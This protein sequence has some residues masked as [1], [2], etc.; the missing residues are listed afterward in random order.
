MIVKRLQSHILGLQSINITPL[1]LICMFNFNHNANPVLDAI[2]KIYDLTKNS[3]IA[4][5]TIKD[6]SQQI[7]IV[8]EFF[9]CLN[10]QAVL[11]SIMIQ[12]QLEN[13]PVSTKRILEHTDLRTSNALYI[14]EV[15]SPLV[16]KEWINPKKDLKFHPLSEYTINNKIIRSVLTGKMEMNNEVKIENSFQL[17]SHFQSKLSE[18]GN[19]RISYNDFI[20]WTYEM[21]QANSCIELAAFTIQLKMSPED[22]TYFLYVCSQFYFGN[23]NCELDNIIR[24]FAPPREEQYKLRNSYKAGTNFLLTSGLLKEIISND[25]FGGK[26]Y[27]ITEKAV[28]AFDKNA[29][30][31]NNLAEGMLQ[32]FE[33]NT[34]AEKK[35]I[36]DSNDQKMVN[37]LH[38]MLSIDQFSELTEKLESQGM[39]KGISVLLYGHPGTGKTETVL[40]LGKTSN[41]YIMMADASKIRS[42]W[43]GET[44]KNMKA[45]FDEYRKAMKEFDEAPILL[46]NE[47]DAIL[48]KRHAVS[49][50]GDQMENAMQNILLQ[51]LEN[52]EGIF[53]AT[54]NLV[55][56]L[57]KAFDRRF[58]YK[59][60]FEKPGTQT[61]IQIWKSK[62]PT[63]KTGVL[64]NICSKFSLSGGQIEN[65]RKKIAVDSLLDEKLKINENYL[66]QLAQQELM[67]EKKNER[68]VI[69]FIR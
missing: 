39:K 54:T 62:F 46:F 63:I 32:H 13:E 29:V 15:L 8:A 36:F 10:E 35:L 12:S 42:K 24:E 16:E 50:R 4:E 7:S 43:V 30:I 34:I 28:H 5:Q 45:L 25:F 33:P 18:R 6:C 20:K 69:G 51:E 65:I 9:E 57:D 55:D 17:I 23:E 68:N 56:N 41:R 1:N 61:L 64:K 26:S 37:K 38:K 48:G 44:E 31:K 60:R 67:L 27:A 53:I 52:F 59:I 49:D 40:Q 58:L 14:N 47:A 19:R 22:T 11:L 21:V 2:E 66:M 3:S